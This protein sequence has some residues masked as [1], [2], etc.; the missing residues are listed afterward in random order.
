MYS[1]RWDEAM[2]KRCLLAMVD[3]ILAKAG[4]GSRCPGWHRCERG[5]G[6][7]HGC[8]HQRVRGA[9]VGIRGG[10]AGGARDDAGGAWRGPRCGSGR[11]LKP[12]AGL[13]LDA[14]M[15][16]V[17][18]GCFRMDADRGMAWRR[19]R[20]RWVP[21]PRCACRSRARSWALGAALPP[22]RAL[23]DLPGVVLP[24]RAREALPDACD[25][26]R[27]GARKLA[28]GEG[29]G[30]GRVGPGVSSGQGRPHGSGA[31]HRGRSG[32]NPPEQSW[33]CHKGGL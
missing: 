5:T 14:R 16:E 18:W 19:G 28:A 33:N 32:Q 31:L 26:A 12:G 15:G 30:S 4:P 17:Y 22:T 11:T 7:V 10:P 29:Y 9:R 3:A 1:R 25:M 27:L 20:W 2:P 23:S 13:C 21:L 24:V 8:A 6:S